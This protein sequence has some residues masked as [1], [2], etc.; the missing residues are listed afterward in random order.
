MGGVGLKVKVVENENI[1]EPEIIITC[2]K[3]DEDIRKILA[4][5]QMF[6]QKLTGTKDNQ[7][8]IIE[9]SK[10]LYIDTVDKKVFFYTSQFVYET[11]M[12]LYELEERLE[13]SDFFRAG[14]S[15]I[16]NFNQIKSLKPDLYGRFQ[17]TLNNG[18][19]LFV[20]RQYAVTI[21][22]KLGVVK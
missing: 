18:E 4:S 2:K 5:I 3:A 20:S 1:L 9:A 17:V 10:I 8:F 11:P 22:Q 12:K 21:K 7:T 19:K 16:I 6:D 13:S 14:K 15:T